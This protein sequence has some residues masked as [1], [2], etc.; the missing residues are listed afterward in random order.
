VTEVRRR[1]IREG[2]TEM[3]RRRRMPVVESPL[4]GQQPS[5]ASG[6][7]SPGRARASR[8]GDMRERR[9]SEG[10]SVYGSR[11]G[12]GLGFFL[13]IY[14]V[15]YL[16]DKWGPGYPWRLHGANLPPIPAP[17]AYRVPAPLSPWGEFVPHPRFLAGNYPRVPAPTGKTAILSGC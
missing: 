16:T 17:P 4:V 11:V 15:L 3:R 5:L 14:R 9:L 12:V 8:F 6:P 2:R 7:G 13:F 10:K 1:P